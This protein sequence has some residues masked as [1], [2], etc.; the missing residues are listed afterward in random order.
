[1]QKL[2]HTNVVTSYAIK[3]HPKSIEEVRCGNYWVPVLISLPLVMDTER[4]IKEVTK[5]FKNL[6]LVDIIGSEAIV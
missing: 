1:M 5:S 2:D 6:G 3:P 4:A